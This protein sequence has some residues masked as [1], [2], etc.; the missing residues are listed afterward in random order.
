MYWKWLLVRDDKASAPA[1][2]RRQSQ[3]RARASKQAQLAAAVPM[4]GD[5]AGLIEIQSTPADARFELELGQ[6]RCL[7]VP[8]SFDADGLRR[9]LDV[10]EAS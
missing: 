5:R 7:R 2:E 4:A 9:L 1:L 3:K 10:L 8:A 6:G